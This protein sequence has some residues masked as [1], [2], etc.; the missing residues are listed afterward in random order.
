MLNCRLQQLCS[1]AADSHT[2]PA[3]EKPCQQTPRQ[4]IEQP[5]AASLSVRNVQRSMKPDWPG[6]Q[7]T[8]L[9]TTFEDSMKDGKVNH[10]APKHTRNDRTAKQAAGPLLN[11]IDDISLSAIITAT[12]KLWTLAQANSSFEAK[13]NMVGI[14]LKS[15]YCGTPL[16][17]KPMLPNIQAQA[18]GNILW[19]SAKL[20]LNPDAFVPGMIDALAAAADK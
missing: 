10:L 4:I 9:Y 5:A 1:W 6:S 7:Q 15:S 17:L 16:R 20:G 14:E 2:T 12:A 3:G 18:V 19:S 8:G 11:Y 13:A